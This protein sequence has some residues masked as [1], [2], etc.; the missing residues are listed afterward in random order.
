MIVLI[1]WLL[2]EKC[3]FL[4]VLFLELK[5]PPNGEMKTQGSKK[6]LGS[7]RRGNESGRRMRLGRQFSTSKVLGG[8]PGA[9]TH[10][11]RVGHHGARTRQSQNYLLLTSRAATVNHIHL[12]NQVQASRLVGGSYSCNDL[13]RC[14]PW[15]SGLQSELAALP[16]LNNVDVCECTSADIIII[17]C[18]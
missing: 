13:W 7:T 14:W 12:T 1:I 11:A 18:A 15:D 6:T 5:L 8:T 10:G 3:W 2:T 16:L 9:C 17:Q 4:Q